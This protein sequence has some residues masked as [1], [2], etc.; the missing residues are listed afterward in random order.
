MT[1]H[2]VSCGKPGEVTL[3]RQCLDCF[4]ST[5]EQMATRTA[6]VM[7]LTGKAAPPPLVQDTLF[8]IPECW[9]ESDANPEGL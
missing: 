8:D 1:G 3:S 5:C 4:S 6:Q 2:C 9:Q 7:Y